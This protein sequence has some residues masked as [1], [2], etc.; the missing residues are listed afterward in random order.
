MTAAAG[1]TN[2]CKLKPKLKFNLIITAF[3]KFIC[4]NNIYNQ[5]DKLARLT[6]LSS[7]VIHNTFYDYSL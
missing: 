3:T 4:I 1:T 7:L 5:V 6:F 2:Y